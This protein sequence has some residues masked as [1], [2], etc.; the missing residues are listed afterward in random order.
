L[1]VCIGKQKK[2]IDTV[3]KEYLADGGG[4]L[5]KA[6]K[7]TLKGKEGSENTREANTNNPS[8]QMR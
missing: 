4:V 8:V 7:N 5:Q 3:S 2:S 6:K 1:G